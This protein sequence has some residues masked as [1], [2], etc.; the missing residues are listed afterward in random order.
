MSK[1]ALIW[2]IEDAPDVQPHWIPVLIGLARH[3]DRQGQG[4]YPSQELLAEYARK[5]DRSI[6][7]DLTALEKAGLIRTGDAGL[8]EHLPPDRRPLV[9]DLAVER[10]RQLTATDWKP[11]S[12][13]SGRKPTSTR[14][15]PENDLPTKQNRRSETNDRK[16][17]STRNDRK[18]TSTRNEAFRNDETAGQKGTTGSPLP[19]NSSN[20]AGMQQQSLI[21]AWSQPLMD[22]LQMEG[23]SVGWGRMSALQWVMVQQLMQSHGI[24][25]LVHI[26]KSRWNPRNPILFG[27]LLLDIW[28]GFTAPPPGSPW[29]PDTIAANHRRK[30]EHP[31]TKPPHCGHPDCDPVSRTRETEDARGIRTL[32]RC[33]D[34]HPDQTK[35]QAA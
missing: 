16:P 21:P 31:S 24:P 6:R 12:G 32:N 10:K 17:T 4:A 18:P 26:A 13:R 28:R 23:I 1:E 25:Y 3:A 5:S 27:T 8:V 30:T 20:Y 15:T 11:T 29:H 33:P 19:P 7:N 35:G 14:S 22:A 34:C 2:V 9:W